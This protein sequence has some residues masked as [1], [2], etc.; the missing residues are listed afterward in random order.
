[1]VKR[2]ILKSFGK[3]SLEK[4][5]E[6]FGKVLGKVVKSLVKSSGKG[7]RKKLGFVLGGVLLRKGYFEKFFETKSPLFPRSFRVV[8]GAGGQASEARCYLKNIS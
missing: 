4:W 7:S 5:D 2:G 1:M 8:A 3:S 6:L